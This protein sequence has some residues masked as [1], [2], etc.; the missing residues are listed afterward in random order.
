[1]K[2]FANCLLMSVSVFIYPF[3][4]FAQSG[5]TLLTAELYG[6]SEGRQYA[7]VQFLPEAQEKELGFSVNSVDKNRV[8]TN[9]DAY[10]FSASRCPA[11]RE[12]FSP[13]PTDSKKFKECR[14]DTEKYIY[15]GDNCIYKAETP[16]YPN[17][18]RLLS[19]ICKDSENGP[20]LAKECNCKYFRYTTN[21]SCGD[22]EKVIDPRSY[23]QENGGEIRYESCQCNREIYPYLFKGDFHSQDFLNDV[24]INC[25]NEKNFL[26]C[27]NFG[28]EMA[29]KCAVDRSY[30]YDDESCQKENSLYGATGIAT[31]FYNGYGD[32]VTLYKECDCPATYSDSC[33]GRSGS[34]FY[35]TDGRLLVCRKR[36]PQCQQGFFKGMEDIGL[37]NCAENVHGSIIQTAGSCVKRDGTTVYRCECRYRQGAWDYTGSFCGNCSAITDHIYC[38]E[39]GQS[40]S[41][42]CLR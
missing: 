39:N 6:A 13:C 32:K 30:Q 12:V 5:T 24:K 29:Y 35:T 10:K 31:V 27:Q 41:N 11:P 15:T 18:N 17:N 40:L 23:C 8:S 14:C 3:Y 1:M 36:H 22:A 28:N 2:K 25:G 33:D 21:A 19:S 26:S 42:S 34:Q 7:D 16:F 4:G 37:H 9:C 20:L 38:I